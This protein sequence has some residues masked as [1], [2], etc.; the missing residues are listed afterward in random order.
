MHSSADDANLACACMIIRSCCA[1]LVRSYCSMPQKAFEDIPD[2]Y[3][4]STR[5]QRP[6]PDRT[7]TERRQFG[8][9]MWEM[10]RLYAFSE[11]AVIID[12]VI[13][14]AKDFPSGVDAWGRVNTLPYGERGWCCAEFSVA[15]KNNRI[16]NLDDP[17]VKEVLATRG[18]PSTVDEYA[19]M[20]DEDAKRPVRFTSKGDRSVV[21]Y[22]FYKMTDRWSHLCVGAAR[23]WLLQCTDVLM[24]LLF[25]HLETCSS[26]TRR[27]HVA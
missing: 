18:W 4:E 13:D 6:M 21:L 11:C 5:T 3:F 24:V 17:E 26:V 27:L 22:N 25:L 20:M 23:V 19:A 1:L 8:F 16:V 10:T 15:H 7:P 9:A 12:P 2:A 14:P